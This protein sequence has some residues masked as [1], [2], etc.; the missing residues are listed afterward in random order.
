MHVWNA[1]NCT[2][3]FSEEE[4]LYIYIYKSNICFQNK[5]IPNEVTMGEKGLTW[6]LDEQIT[7]IL[8][9]H[10]YFLKTYWWAKEGIFL[11]LISVGTKIK[12]KHWRVV[13]AHYHILDVTSQQSH[14]T[15]SIIFAKPFQVT[16]TKF[17]RTEEWTIRWKNQSYS[18]E[19]YLLIFFS[20]LRILSQ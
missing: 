5:I 11:F 12:H 6:N 17:V 18:L 2:V 4:H 3:I 8:F 1:P 13:I 19:K 20:F 14:H 9:L 16:A 10:S 7:A 15:K